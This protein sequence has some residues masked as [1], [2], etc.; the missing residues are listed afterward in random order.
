MNL[1]TFEKTAL[2]HGQRNCD[3]ALFICNSVQLSSSI[4]PQNSI[5]GNLE[6]DGVIFYFTD[7]L[8]W[9]FYSPH[10]CIISHRSSVDLSAAAAASLAAFSWPELSSIKTRRFISRWRLSAPFW[11]SADPFYPL[12][13]T[14]YTSHLM[15]PV[16]V[17]NFIH[18]NSGKDQIM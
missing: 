7:L 1:H 16:I 12:L 5:C 17:A 15:C 6:K 3:S 2:P 10:S 14:D 18:S 9:A 4:F 11:N 8:R 13:T